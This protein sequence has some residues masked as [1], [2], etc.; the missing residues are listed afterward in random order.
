[1]KLS[2]T[3]AY[4]IAVDSPESSV[5]MEYLFAILVLSLQ[6]NLDEW[7]AGFTTFHTPAPAVWSPLQG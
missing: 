6:S 3:A 5:L 1:M 4:T 7:S 2:L